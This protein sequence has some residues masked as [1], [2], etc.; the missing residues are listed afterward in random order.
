MAEGLIKGDG[1]KTDGT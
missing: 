1:S